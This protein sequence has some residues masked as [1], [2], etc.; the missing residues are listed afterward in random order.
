MSLAYPHQSS[1]SVERPGWRKLVGFNIFTGIIGAV[2][3]YIIGWYIG[4][5]LTTTPYYEYIRVNTLEDDLA[6]ILAYSFGVIG[7]L[8]G[9]GFA[10]YP[11][12]RMLGRPASLREKETGGAWRYF[13]LS[14]DHK[15][16]G[17]QYLV[18][19]GFFFFV[20]GLNAMLIR[21]ELLHNTPEFVGPEK[22]LT[23]VGLHSVVMLGTLTSAVLG[24]FANYF[25]PIMIGARRM[26]F[27]RIEA[28]TFWLLMAAGVILLSTIFF[29]GFPTGWTGYEPLNDQALMGMD[30]YILFFALVGISMVLLGMNMIVTIVTMRAPGVTW[31]RLPIFCWAT[32]VTAVLMVLAAPML[33]GTLLMAALDRAIGTSFFLTLGGGSA[34]LFE[35]LF[36]FFGH[37]E[38]Y[39]LALPGFGL[40]LEMLPVFARKP[41]WGYRIAV[42][43][44]LGVG[45][46]SF[47]VWQHH[48]FV[49]GINADLRPFYMLSTEIISIPTGFVF[50]AFIGT[51]WRSRITFTVPM[52]FCFAWA[53]NFLIG[54]ASGVVLSDVPTNAQLHGSFFVIA[55]FHYT[56]MGGLGFAFVGAIYYYVPKMF[57]FKLNE[58]IGKFQFW[59]MFLTFNA[60]FL[61]IFALGLKGMARRVTF[62]PADLITLNR[63][64]SIAA[65][66]LFASMLLLVYNVV[67]SLVFERERATDN[68]WHSKG[69]EWQVPTPVPVDNF[70]DKIP[71]MRDFDP[72]DYGVPVS[73]G[74]AAPAPAGAG[75]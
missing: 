8:V 74:G 28:L 75:A 20:G 24:P 3:G 66:L 22:Y 45:L 25:V 17:I 36:W 63:V 68:P 69:M 23:I 33:I 4:K 67:Y 29:G 1:S 60:T 34:Y 51:I 48:L 26:A 73:G 21:T 30:S 5:A 43:G 53:F 65:Y 37:P 9:M 16:V 59:A 70:P 49:S 2:I 46:M 61:P 32:F 38:V 41:L 10:N 64:V 15:V 39:V 14:T 72:Y 71:D 58:R 19:V 31:G 57:G 7:F 44:F 55:H 42:A 35:N 40:I 13:G 11:V 54:G 50:L 47:F 18:G 6:L 62:Y 52:L 56:I 12:G 27:P